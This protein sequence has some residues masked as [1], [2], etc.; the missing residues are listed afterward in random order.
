MIKRLRTKRKKCVSR[1]KELNCYWKWLKIP[2]RQR[3]P[4][5]LTWMWLSS[6]RICFMKGSVSRDQPR[7]GR[8][9]CKKRWRNWSNEHRQLFFLE[10]W[11]WQRGDRVL[12][13]KFFFP[14]PFHSNGDPWVYLEMNRVLLFLIVW[15]NWHYNQSL[16]YKNMIKK[17]WTHFKWKLQM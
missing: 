4:E 14:F 12:I 6:C 11:L 17:S 3:L 2:V 8:S 10:I 15:Q 16:F 7:L 1:K 5:S 9:I 13:C